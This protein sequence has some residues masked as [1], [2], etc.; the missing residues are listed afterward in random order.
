MFMFVSSRFII[1]KIVEVIAI[2][3]ILFI[4]SHAV[5][6]SLQNAFFIFHISVDIPCDSDWRG[7]L[8]HELGV[9]F[10]GIW[11]L[12]WALIEI[13]QVELVEVLICVHKLLKWSRIRGL[14]FEHKNPKTLIQ[15]YMPI[16]RLFFI[17]LI[18]LKKNILKIL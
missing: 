18:N 15:D 6:Y 2:L 7:V 14:D 1:M 12:K 17:Q 5:L 11:A 10:V 9:H 8:I 16:L 3:L 4:R 13:A